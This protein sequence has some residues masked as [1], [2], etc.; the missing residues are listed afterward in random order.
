MLRADIEVEQEVSGVYEKAADEVDDP[1]LRRLF[2][3]MQSHEDYHAEVFE[4]LLA[5]EEGSG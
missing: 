3:R 5:S 4:D 2:R 1:S